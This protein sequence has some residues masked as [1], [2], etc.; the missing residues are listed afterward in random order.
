MSNI[1]EL[2]DRSIID[3]EAGAWIIKLDGDTELSW[4][5]REAFKE[6]MGRSPMHREA[7]KSLAQFWGKMNVL[8]ELALSLIH[9]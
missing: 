9:I 2:P 1:K 4:E 6:W 8:T 7:V 3:E 5:Q